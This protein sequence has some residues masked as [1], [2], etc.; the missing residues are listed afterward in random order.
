MT[1]VSF[2]ALLTANDGYLRPFNLLPELFN[3]CWSYT[4]SFNKHLG[5][6][7]SPY[8]RSCGNRFRKFQLAFPSRNSQSKVFGNSKQDLMFKMSTATATKLMFA[9]LLAMMTL[10]CAVGKTLDQPGEKDRL[11]SELDGVTE[12]NVKSLTF[13]TRIL[14]IPRKENNPAAI[15]RLN[16]N[17]RKKARYTLNTIRL[18]DDD[19]SIETALINYLFAKQVV[20]RLR[21]QMDV[22]DLQRK[23]SYWKQCAFNAK[24]KPI[25]AIQTVRDVSRIAK[26]QF[27]TEPAAGKKNLAC[28]FHVCSHE[29]K[30]SEAVNVS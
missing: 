29:H 14:T 23:R 26:I 21:S 11:I 16:L 19:G 9:M 22:S 6:E 25:F 30:N 1:T 15:N 18:V 12:E 2:L 13:K 5:R 20:N 10:S 8:V 4:A 27:T 3:C 17:K 24:I 28:T 7:F